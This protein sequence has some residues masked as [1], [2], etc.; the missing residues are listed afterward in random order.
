MTWRWWRWS[1]AS[2]FVRTPVWCYRYD[3]AVVEV[4][5]GK[6]ILVED[7]LLRQEQ[8]LA[9]DKTH[10]A[11]ERLHKEKS[12]ANQARKTRLKDAR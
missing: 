8:Q 11:L 10:A 7:D 9:R 12:L 3:L 6:F 5:Q 2:S 1:R 4:E